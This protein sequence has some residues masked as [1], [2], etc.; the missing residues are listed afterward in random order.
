MRYILA[1]GR[2]HS[3]MPGQYMTW[4]WDRYIWLMTVM[5]PCAFTRHIQVR[6]LHPACCKWWIDQAP[7][8]HQ[9][10]VLEPF[11]KVS[12]FMM[13]A[14]G[15]ST[16]S[17]ASSE[18]AGRTQRITLRSKDIHIEAALQSSDYK[19]E[20]RLENCSCSRMQMTPLPQVLNHCFIPG[21]VTASDP[22][23]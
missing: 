12:E 9:T 6:Q 16:E 18:Y 15:H 23:A 11:S 22:T 21:I 3:C 8:A 17:M 7:G 19:P 13:S 5:Q 2:Y 4:R 1:Y 10:D 20:Y 14:V